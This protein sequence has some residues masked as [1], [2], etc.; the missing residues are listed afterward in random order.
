MDGYAKYRYDWDM[1]AQKFYMAGGITRKVDGRANGVFC[2]SI[3]LNKFVIERAEVYNFKWLEIHDIAATR[4]DLKDDEMSNFRALDMVRSDDGSI[5]LIF[6]SAG[7][8]LMQSRNTRYYVYAASGIQVARF[9]P[10]GKFK[11]LT[12]VRRKPE[13]AYDWG[14]LSFYSGYKDGKIRLVFIGGNQDASQTK[15]TASVRT[16][17]YDHFYSASIDPNGVATVEDLGALGDRK[18]LIAPYYILGNLTEI[19]DGQY[20]WLNYYK[21]NQQFGRLM[22]K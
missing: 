8:I 19:R 14:A 9:G 15:E 7:E 11:W 12:H 1:K 22:I 5:D 6:E 10:D 2:Q 17:G 18:D 16:R 20:L 3:D 13:A 4:Y 21:T